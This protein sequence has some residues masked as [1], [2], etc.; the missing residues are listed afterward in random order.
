MY[1]CACIEPVL[2]IPTCKSLK[3]ISQYTISWLQR[4][5]RQHR[6]VIYKNQI[7]PIV[8]L[9]RIICCIFINSFICFLTFQSNISEMAQRILVWRYRLS[10]RGGN[11]GDNLQPLSLWKIWGYSQV[12]PKLNDTICFRGGEKGFGSECNRSTILYLGQ[13]QYR[14]KW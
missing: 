9:S 4:V 10:R 6:K 1:L 3:T 8:G 13:I 2:S 11:A 5:H 14:R 12:V 7:A